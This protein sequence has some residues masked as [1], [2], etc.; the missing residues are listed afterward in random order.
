MVT[1]PDKVRVRDRPPFL[2]TLILGIE[3]GFLSP[4][5]AESHQLIGYRVRIC[6][7]YLRSGSHI[8]CSYFRKV[9][10]FRVD[11]PVKHMQMRGNISR[12]WGKID[13]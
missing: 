2:L 9:Q 8:S 13:P 4:E 3:R 5:L 12:S 10:G 7:G 1:R 11:L 6:H